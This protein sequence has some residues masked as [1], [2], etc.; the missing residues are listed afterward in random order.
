MK[1]RSEGYRSLSAAQNA[2]QWMSST[3]GGD[4]K[5]N[6]EPL[7]SESDEKWLKYRHM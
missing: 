6:Q 1:R 2:V 5:M 3:I 4:E 7:A